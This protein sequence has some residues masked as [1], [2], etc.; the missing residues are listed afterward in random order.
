MIQNVDDKDFYLRTSIEIF[1]EDVIGEGKDPLPYLKDFVKVD[2]LYVM[3]F[4]AIKPKGFE[5][6]E[7]WVA[8][9]QV[10]DTGSGQTEMYRYG[11][12]G[13]QG[14]RQYMED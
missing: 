8:K 6:K 4:I 12:A 7:Q 2:D 5:P 13:M 14:W 11:S 1:E 3:A 10:I 9:D